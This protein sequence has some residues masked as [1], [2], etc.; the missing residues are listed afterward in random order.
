MALWLAAKKAA[1]YLK[2]KNP[3]SMIGER[4]IRVL[5]KNGFPHLPIDSRML[6]NVETF[7]QDMS[8]YIRN[9]RYTRPTNNISP[10]RP[11]KAS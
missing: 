10:I 5:I 9:Q 2:D 3:E 1:K 4:T 11:I 6:I 7:D 8:E